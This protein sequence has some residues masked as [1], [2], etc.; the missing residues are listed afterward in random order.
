MEGFTLHSIQCILFS[1]MTHT[2]FTGAPAA[3]D[4]LRII[5][6][7]SPL[8]SYCGKMFGDLGADVLLVEPVDGC[9][10]RREAPFVANQPGLGSSLAFAYHNTSKR[11][12]TLNLECAEGQA[13][14]RRLAAKAD[15]VLEGEQPG[16]MARR[17]LGFD[18]LASGNRRLV[19]TSITPFGQDGPYAQFVAE[20]L[21]GLAMG[22]LLYLGGYPDTAPTRVWGNQAYLCAAMYGAVAAMLALTHA[23]LAGEGQHIDVSMQEC[24][25]MAMETAVQYVDLE[26]TIRKRYAGEQR[27]AGTGVFECE[28]GYIYMMAGGIGANKFWP[29]SLQWLIEEQVSSVERLRGPEWEKID[30]L[31]TEEAKRI[32]AEVFGPWAK[33]RTK[34]YL[35]HEG[36]RHHIPLAPINTTADIVASRQLE[37]RRYF[38]HV[39]HAKRSEPLLM[40]G[41]PYLLSATPW[42]IS[43]R[44]PELG[45]HNAEVYDALGLGTGELQ[46]LYGARVI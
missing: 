8:T 3:L 2:E 36:Q 24:V 26:G 29:S 37:H 6:I 16:A 21:I 9:R 5:E 44:A 25:V 22:G 40:P 13:L 20:D 34:A 14:F 28:D 46:R 7:A 27:F 10:M 33:H 42:R 43:R 17:R 12:I 4:G 32:F 19:M 18:A 11:G 1:T 38:V 15:L 23:D 35:Y 39:P 31:Q 45:E 41:A 30:Y